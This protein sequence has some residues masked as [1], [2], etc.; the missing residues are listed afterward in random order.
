[1]RQR[2]IVIVSSW[3]SFVALKTR[4]EVG[5]GFPL[6][7]DS[8]ST[9]VTK[10]MGDIETLGTLL[11]EYE[12]EYEKR[13]RQTSRD[14]EFRRSSYLLLTNTSFSFLFYLVLLELS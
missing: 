7:P 8:M 1:M 5:W 10:C 3:A 2:Y 4:V 6:I 12:Y 14:F 9:I 13:E 11:Y